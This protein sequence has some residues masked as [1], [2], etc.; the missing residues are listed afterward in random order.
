MFVLEMRDYSEQRDLVPHLG[1]V[2][3]LEDTDGDG[4]Y[5]KATVFA[6]DRSILSTSMPLVTSRP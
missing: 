6:A 5:D 2:R 1:R 3:L 4:R